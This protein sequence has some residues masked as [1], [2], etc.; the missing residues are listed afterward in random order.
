[1]Y[2][3]LHKRYIKPSL[4]G[5]ECSIHLTLKDVYG[6]KSIS[7]FQELIVGDDDLNFEHPV[8]VMFEYSI[9]LRKQCSRYQL[10]STW[11]WGTI[12]FSPQQL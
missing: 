7:L 11:E 4:L 1:M 9:D 5:D 8:E 6:I 3:N 2:T 12:T 10:S